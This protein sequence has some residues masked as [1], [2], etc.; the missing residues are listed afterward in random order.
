MQMRHYKTEFANKPWLR[1]DG[2]NVATKLTSVTFDINMNSGTT[3]AVEF[4]NDAL[5]ESPVWTVGGTITRTVNNYTVTSPIEDARF[6]RFIVTSDAVV[7]SNNHDPYAIDEVKVFGYEKVVT[8][9]EKVDL[10]LAALPDYPTTITEATTLTLPAAGTN[11]SSIAWTSDNEAVINP[12]TGVVTLPATD[13]LVKLTA[14]LTLN[15]ATGNKIYDITVK[16]SG[17]AS[18]PTWTETFE[19]LSI[20]AGS[21]TKGSHVGVNGQ[22]FFYTL[23]RGDQ[24][25]DNRALCTHRFIN[26]YIT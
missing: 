17:G 3:L 2:R 10:D 23:T 7:S 22:E 4:T 1:F 6:I 21:Y 15:A 12:T 11:G 8:D 26:N 19:D 14:G 25:L 18:N 9:Q 13:T 16:A 24:T 20:P 5:A